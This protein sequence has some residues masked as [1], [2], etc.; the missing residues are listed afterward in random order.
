MEFRWIIILHLLIVINVL[1]L[2]VIAQSAY[3][4]ELVNG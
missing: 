4:I 3:I 1:D 2:H